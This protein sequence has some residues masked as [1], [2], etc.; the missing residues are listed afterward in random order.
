MR[1]L[2]NSTYILLA[3][4]LL[5][6]AESQADDRHKFRLARQIS[7]FN[8]IVKELPPSTQMVLVNAIYF[9]AGWADPFKKED[10]KKATFTKSNGKTMKVDMMQQ[11]RRALYHEDDFMQATEK[12]FIGKEYS[13]LLILPREGVTIESIAERL[14]QGHESALDKWEE[15]MLT[16]SMPKFKS[17]FGTSLKPM[18]AD[19]GIKDAFTENADFSGISKTPLLI[20]DV[21]Q[22]TYIAVDEEGAEAAA[23][24]AVQM[25]MMSAFRPVEK[26]EMILN[27]PFIYA[28]KDNRNGE[29]LFMGKMGNPNKQ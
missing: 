3:L 12:P 23:V 22:K 15:C 2:F 28:I 10:T 27:R 8:S 6:P 4:T 20:D 19:M 29:I 16:L 5:V 9:K 18:L 17:E 7:T 1:K 24:T 21:L 26:K 11:A 13:M 25:A 14:V